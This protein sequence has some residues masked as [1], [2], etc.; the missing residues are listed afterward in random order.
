MAKAIPKAGSVSFAE[1]SV[2]SVPH[3]WGF[4]STRRTARL[5]S[6]LKWKAAVVKDYVDAS[7]ALAK[8]EFRNGE[9]IRVDVDRA[10]LITESYKQTEGQPPAIR[11]AKAFSNICE[12]IPVSI[13]DGELIVGDANSAP[14]ELRWYPEI[15][16]E[17]MVGSVTE[18]S[19]SDMV[20]DAERKEIVEDIC[21]Y[22][23]GRNVSDRVRT[24]LPESEF[25][26]VWAGLASPMEAKLWE[27]G[28]VSMAYDYS[29]L[30]REG[31]KA[32][33]RRA[34][35]SLGELEKKA[36][37]MPLAEYEEKRNNWQAMII[38]GRAIILFA[39]R[40]AKE[41]ARLA[42]TARG[43]RRR[44]L[45]EL[46]GILNRVPAEPAR[47]FHEAIQ[48]YW[49]IE[50]A[51]KFLAV[52][53]LGG[54]SRIDQ[55]LWPYYKE[56]MDA[57]RITRERALEL[58][59]CLFLKIQEVGIALE[60][61]VTFTG[62][63]GGEIFY[64]LN[65][66]GSKADGTDASND[67]SC[68]VLEAMANLH[69][70]QPPISILYHDKIS[71]DVVER[72]IDLQRCGTGHPSWFNED[73]IRKAAKMRGYS[74]KD[75]LRTQIGGCVTN[76]VTGRYVQAGGTPG[77]A[78]I[79]VPRVLEE[80]LY[81]GGDAGNEGRPDKPK[82]MDP[83]K[84]RSADDLLDAFISRIF[85]YV[86]EAMLA[87]NAVQKLLMDTLPD[88]T[89]SLLFDEPLE[90]GDDIKKVQKEYDTYPCVFPLGLIT[91][92]DSLA[93]VQKLVFDERKYTMEQLI[94]ALRANWEGYEAMRQDFVHAPKY[95]NDDDYADAWA[96]KLFHGFTKAI[97]QL[98]D[99]WG[100]EVVIDGGTA[101]GYQTAGITVGATPDGR[102]T[103]EYLTDGSRSP[104]A[105]VDTNGP[106][107]VL[108]SVG[109]I[110]FTHM[111]LFNQRFMP[112]FLEGENKR[113]FAAYLREWY[114][115]GTIPH[116]QFNIVD[117]AVLRDAQIH[118]EKYHDLQVRVAG[119]SAFWIDLP[120]GTQDSIIARTEHGL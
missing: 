43:E 66:C 115:K 28:T 81:E 113:L 57:G 49:I 18:G 85:F 21:G 12:K 36:S 95:G 2:K 16:A 44:E 30:F 55:I 98:K 48:F 51:A 42:K 91:V 5:R 63:A 69:V 93:A 56:D 73:L 20:T 25:P 40:Y 89:N 60:Y 53:A 116:I 111:D 22:W 110:P 23:S 35:L 32:R 34:E 3:S 27:M 15:C 79:L 59:E 70:N 90:R 45:N 108:N 26:D 6:Q 17:F 76:L 71:P 103:S 120:K 4:G 102:R 78:G 75:V 100:W 109:K 87:W 99:A 52:Y 10:R 107:A 96:V 47:T 1:T 13:K 84:M 11:V 38:S 64:C 14:D 62:K 104:A 86:R 106:T 92:A 31:V 77:M 74:Q 46:A 117:T 105:G 58:I 119:Y 7:V 67:L 61:P 94:E 19:F 68:I 65:T 37:Q 54:G 8:C 33:I 72:G 9:H 80:A 112:A 41:A 97:S 101:S 118:P 83:L 88:P 29:E 50:V 114:E 24:V 39:Q 82:T